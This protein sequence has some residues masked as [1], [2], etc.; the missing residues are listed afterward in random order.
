MMRQYVLTPSMGK[1]LIARAM[2]R[3][4]A[5][6]AAARKGTLAIV[7]GSTNGY[8]AEEVLRSLGYDGFDRT[9]FRR[10]MVTPPHTN[11]VSLQAQFP[12]DVVIVE[13]KW[14][15][16]KELFDFVDSMRAGDVILKGANAL[17]AELGRAACLIAHP[18]GGT[19]GASI[20]AVIGRRVRLIIPVG[21]EKRVPGDLDDLMARVNAATT[22]GPRM[23]IIPGEVFTELEA[24]ELLTSAKATLL[25]A[26]GIHGAEGAL[27]LG[28]EGEASQVA[29][30]DAVFRALIHEPPCTA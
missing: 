15:R 29:E 7:A 14:Q 25:A 10:G 26:G 27:W 11:P 13:G 18:M 9:G 3:H 12:G 17:D 4:E 23:M 22:E 1:R 21:L 2:A 20:P 30:F 8:V 24:I 5:V 28:V 6:Q 16:G 19:L